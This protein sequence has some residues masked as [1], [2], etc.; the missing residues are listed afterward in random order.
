MRDMGVFSG[1]LLIRSFD[2]AERVY[3]A[4]KC[5][6]YALGY[7]LKNIPKKNKTMV[8]QDFIFL[9]IVCLSCATF[10]FIDVYALLTGFFGR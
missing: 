5:R 8:L 1:Q 9:F 6:G 3:N 2:R 4:M 10:R 7:A